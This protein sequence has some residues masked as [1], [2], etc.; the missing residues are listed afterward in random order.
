MRLSDGAL[1]EF[2][3]MRKDAEKSF[4]LLFEHVKKECTNPGTEIN[5]VVRYNNRRMNRFNLK[6]GDV[7]ACY[8]ITLD[9]IDLRQ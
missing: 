3:D 8:R 7:E 4:Y 1:K 5:V 9:L 6:T 2:D